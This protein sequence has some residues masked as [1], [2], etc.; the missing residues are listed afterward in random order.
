MS[1][2]GHADPKPLAI[3]L[4]STSTTAVTP[5]RLVYATTVEPGLDIPPI[6]TKG[7]TGDRRRY[8]NEQRQ[9]RFAIPLTIE[10]PWQFTTSMEWLLQASLGAVVGSATADPVTYGYS[11][12]LPSLTI[13][14]V[15]GTTTHTYT[16]VK[17]N[18]ATMQGATGGPVNLRLECMA[19]D[20]SAGGTAASITVSPPQVGVYHDCSVE[21]ATGTV[22]NA[23]S[24]S[25]VLDNGLEAFYG[26]SQKPNHL[27]PGIRSAMLTYSLPD[28]TEL[29]TILSAHTAHTARSAQLQIAFG[30]N[31]ALLTL[32]NTRAKV[33][34]PGFAE[35]PAARDVEER[36][37]YNGSDDQ[38]LVTMTDQT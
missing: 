9:G 26:T 35:G 24:V 37:Y 14:H 18:R 22:Q 4:Q 6:E 5:T 23:E 34:P 38:L 2:R 33:M 3:G 25:L 36:G 27:R 11:A 17:I 31:T 1:I 20:F 12:T 10:L 30:G 29:D 13:E 21:A 32:T 28:S 16:G 15:R 19:L 7:T 8:A